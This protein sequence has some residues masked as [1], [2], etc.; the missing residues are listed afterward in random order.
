M[1]PKSKI[2]NLPIKYRSWNIV[3]MW[4]INDLPPLISPAIPLIHTPSAVLILWLLVMQVPTLLIFVPSLPKSP[5]QS[6]T[7]FQ[8]LPWIPPPAEAFPI[9]ALDAWIPAVL[10]RCPLHIEHTFSVLIYLFRCMVCLR[11]GG[12]LFI[13]LCP[14]EGPITDGQS[15]QLLYFKLQHGS[16]HCC[17]F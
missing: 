16:L 10:I 1:G 8:V 17:S 2:I 7:F 11:L 9:V 6:P 4:P 13:F 5:Y 14:G 3:H 15:A 12:L